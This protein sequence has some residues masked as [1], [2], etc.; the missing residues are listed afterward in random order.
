MEL[1]LFNYDL[2]ESFIAQSPAIPRDSSKLMILKDN[3]IIH[4]H[5]RDII[6]YLNK[7]D[8]P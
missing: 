6:N 3:K 2:P 8:V 5:F 7:D 4:K 1:E